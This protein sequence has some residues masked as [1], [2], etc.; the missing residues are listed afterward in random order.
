[1]AAFGQNNSYCCSKEHPMKRFVVLALALT[2]LFLNSWAAQG[3]ESK[4]TPT[5]NL[6]AVLRVRVDPNLTISCQF[7]LPGKADQSFKNTEYRYAVLDKDGVQV[8][9]ALVFQLPLRTIALPKD[10]RSVTDA[11]DAKF[12]KDKLKAGEEYFLVVS[13]REVAGLAKFKAP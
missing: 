10:Q 3:D 2:T 6:D 11:T 1:M 13:V 5:A 7:E 12:L 9:G 8:R 4:L